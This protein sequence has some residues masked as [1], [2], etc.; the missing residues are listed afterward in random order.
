MSAVGSLE[1]VRHICHGFFCCIVV[2]NR[3]EGCDL[4]RSLQKY[5]YRKKSTLLSIYLTSSST[6][7]IPFLCLCFMTLVTN[8]IPNIPTRALQ[9]LCSG[10]ICLLSWLQLVCEGET[11]RYLNVRVNLL[12]LLHRSQSSVL[13]ANMHMHR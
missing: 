2:F 11:W 13:T 3:V 8:P 5:G 7:L 6:H 10:Y 12:W 1:A 4:M 9:Q